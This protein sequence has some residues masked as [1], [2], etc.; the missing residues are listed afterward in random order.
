MAIW[1]PDEKAD[2]CLATIANTAG[3]MNLKCQW[4]KQAG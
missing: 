2:S 4:W 1:V 3:Q